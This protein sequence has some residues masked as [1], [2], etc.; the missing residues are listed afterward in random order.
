M[1]APAAEARE[2]RLANNEI[3]FRTVNES[4]QELAVEFGGGDDY[5]FICECARRGCLDRIKLSRQQYEQVRAE[6]TRFFV[7]P[8]H[9]DISVELVV[10]TTPTFVI[11]EKDGHAGVVAELADPRD[12]DS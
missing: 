9:E 3:L 12:G 10:E 6:G 7:V 4:I 8:G 1:S 5:E 11:V 2:E